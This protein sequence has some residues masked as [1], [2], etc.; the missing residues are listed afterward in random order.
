MRRTCRAAAGKLRL[1]RGGRGE[2][3]RREAEGKGENDWPRERGAAW[4]ESGGGWTPAPFIWASEPPSPLPLWPLVSAAL[5][6]AL[7]LFSLFFFFFLIRCARNATMRVIFVRAL[8]CCLVEGDCFFCFVFFLG[9]VEGVF[10]V[11]YL[12]SH[13]VGGIRGVVRVLGGV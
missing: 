8:V 12:W 4:V 9:D 13:P 3:R 7:W 10:V 5:G 11:V 1:R 6:E 2:E